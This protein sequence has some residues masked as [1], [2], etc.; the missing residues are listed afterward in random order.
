MLRLKNVNLGRRRR[1]RH[2][3][4]SS[5]RRR[6][7]ARR[8]RAR[9]ARR[10]SPSRCR[11]RRCRRCPSRLRA[12]RGCCRRP[13]GR[14][15]AAV[16]ARLVVAA[17]VDHLGVIVVALAQDALEL[18]ADPQVEVLD[19]RDVR[20]PQEVVRRRRR[21]RSPTARTPRRLTLALL[22]RGARARAVAARAGPMRC[23]RRLRGR[24]RARA[25]VPTLAFLRA[26][27]R[28]AVAARPDAAAVLRDARAPRRWARAGGRDAQ[29]LA[30]SPGP[31]GAVCE[32]ILWLL[33]LWG[34]PGN[35]S[36]TLIVLLELFSRT[37]LFFNSRQ[38]PP[39]AR[40]RATPSPLIAGGYKQAGP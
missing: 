38:P 40:L 13:S 34:F 29:Q 22:A 32:T 15:A 10:A 11:R 26:T 33:R 8:G 6:R 4:R 20:E 3:G 39:R 23:R 21:R 31:G 5:R 2:R 30:R 35:G 37:R 36:P 12:R 25:L 27:A 9:A 19:A 1:R 17:A 24:R 28:P 14:V 18:L 7:H 16:A